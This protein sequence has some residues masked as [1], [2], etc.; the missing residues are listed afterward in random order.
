MTVVHNLYSMADDLNDTI[1]QL[2]IL[3]SSSKDLNEKREDLEFIA[4]ELKELVSGGQ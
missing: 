1:S 4:R 2:S 3:L